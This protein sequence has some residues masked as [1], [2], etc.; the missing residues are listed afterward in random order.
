VIDVTARHEAQF[1]G[2]LRSCSEKPTT[3]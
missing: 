3:A 2:E 1:F